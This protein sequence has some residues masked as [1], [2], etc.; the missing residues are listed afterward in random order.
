MTLPHVNAGKLR[1]LASTGAAR[2]K[3]VPDLPTVAEAALPGYEA[4]EWFG[5]F[6]PAATAGDVVRTLNI[7][8]RGIFNAA[9]VQQQFAG[10]GAEI[11][12]MDVAAFSNFV[13]NQIAKW[14]KV[15]KD[16]KIQTE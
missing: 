4:N 12:D 5:A 3:V 1:A 9:D 16:A 2:S 7:T 11:I 6:A 15:V 8:I 14:M 13:K 10:Q